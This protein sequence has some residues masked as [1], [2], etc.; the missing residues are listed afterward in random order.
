MRRLFF[1]LAPSCK[2]AAATDSEVAILVLWAA[3]GWLPQGL[4]E[5][6]S[7]MAVPGLRQLAALPTAQ[8]P[9]GVP[10]MTRQ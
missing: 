8:D 6:M 9:S 2:E 3:Q 5:V 4:R 7:D 1:L 10:G